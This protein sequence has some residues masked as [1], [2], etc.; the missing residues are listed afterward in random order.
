MSRR[1]HSAGK[2]SSDPAEPDES[3]D[4]LTSGDGRGEPHGRDHDIFDLAGSDAELLNSG[5]I[6]DPLPQHTPLFRAL[7][8]G[9]ETVEARLRA[10]GGKPLRRGIRVFWAILAAIGV[11]LLVGP[12]INK[13]LDFDD[14]IASADVDEVDWVARDAK[15][16]Y[17]VERGGDGGFATEVRESYTAD[18]LNGPEAK[19]SRSLVTEFQGHDARFELH[20]ATIDGEPAKVR[21]DRG[22]ATTTIDLR[23]ADGADFDGKQRIALSY[24][25]HNLVTSETDEAGGR[26]LDRWTWPVLAPSWPQATKGIEV[27]FTLP[28]EVN[29][30]LVRRPVA[31]VGWLLLSATER[32]TPEETTADGVRYALTNDQTLPPNAD[33]E[34]RAS[35]EPG[36]FAQPPTTP[37]FWLQTYGPLI[38]LA[39][40]AVLLL[41]ALAARR[42]VWADSAGRPW[43][44]PR[45]EPPDELTPELAARLLGKRRHVELAELLSARPGVRPPSDHRGRVSRRRSARGSQAA[46]ASRSTGTVRTDHLPGSGPLAAKDRWIAAVA[47]AG[48]RAGRLGNL[49]TVWSRTAGWSQ[50]DPI[51]ERK[52]RWIPDSYVR[53]TFLLAPLALTVLQWGLLRQLSHQV[54]LLVVWWPAVFVL[55]STAL[56]IAITAAAARPRPLTPDGA[57]AA[58]Q[59]KGVD[60]YANSTRLLDRGPID[61]PLLGYAML[62]ESPRRAG[63]ALTRL[64]AVEAADRS[65]ERGWRT[66]SFIT[67]PALL[68]LAASLAVL[69][70]SIVT[71]STLPPPY[72][73]SVDRITEY[74]DLPGSLY[75][76]VTGFEI[77]AELTRGDDGRA[78]L[79]VT[80]HHDV[81]FDAHSSRVPQFVREWPTSRL[82]QDLGFD[83]ES[84]RIDGRD[85]PYRELPQSRTQSTAMTTQFEDALD[86][87]HRIDISY[88]LASPVVEAP[89]GPDTI[90]QLRWTAWY[91]FWEHEYYT[92]PSNPFDGSAPVRPIRLSFA[93]APELVDAAIGGGWIDS[94]YQRGD[95]G[96][97][98]EDGNWYEPWVRTADFVSDHDEQ[99]H[100][101]RIGSERTRADGAVV[102]EIDVDAIELVPEA[103]DADA[104]VSGVPDPDFELDTSE[105]GKYEL[106]L[107]SDLGVRIDFRAG[108]FT[109]VSADAY[110]N[111]RLAYDLPYILLLALAAVVIAASAGVLALGLRGRRRPSASLATVAFLAIPLLA[112]AQCVLFFWNVGPMD[113]DD[114][115]I[116]GPVVA[117]GFML[118]AVLAETIVV[119]RRGMGE[120]GPHD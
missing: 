85:A 69:A 77:E 113:G 34:I 24:R 25:L 4:G 83:L 73:G 54:I 120:T 6:P 13:P 52:L 71:V 72:P 118:A 45:S 84:V 103:A 65:I 20:S 8:R 110:A 41:F 99:L 67:V 44:L 51:V 36:T 31:Y 60:A 116:I 107:T 33:I 61:E 94:D 57:L 64:A 22:P 100:K 63:D 81:G 87:D 53:D 47:R 119:A 28:T 98:L 30:A 35:F 14:I 48:R 82:G 56:A 46:R 70:G 105:L 2:G 115:R 96:D 114:A 89:N 106:G 12:I 21:I 49:P 58:Q 9:L 23:R 112:A 40:L 109:G 62:A 78:R 79:E 92:N 102:R 38:P 5:W 17:A 80:E 11:L 32:L 97:P 90:Q 3:R 86:G 68:A 29:D 93:L 95:D 59:L 7:A 111:Y 88:S 16:D 101:V 18:F 15:I 104:P 50:N 43:Y 55:V 91:D 76:Q 108:T 26:L 27:S 42:I 19:V 117:G 10:R 74:H 39:L 1:D 75:T 37:L 66:E